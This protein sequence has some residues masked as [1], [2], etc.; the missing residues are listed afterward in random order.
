MSRRT[1]KII[2]RNGQSVTSLIS[3][4]QNSI[5]NA[6]KTKK[7]S[8]FSLPFYR[9]VVPGELGPD[10]QDGVGG[11]LVGRVHVPGVEPEGVGAEQEEDLVAVAAAQAEAK[12]VPVEQPE[13]KNLGKK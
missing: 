6:K 7:I 1:L 9:R 10:V 5:F 2:W 13:A 3:Y 4:T 12:R 11:L 8:L